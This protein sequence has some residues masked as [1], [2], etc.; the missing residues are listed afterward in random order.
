[1]AAVTI[2]TAGTY[3]LATDASFSGRLAGEQI[4]LNAAAILSITADVSIGISGGIPL[5]GA[6][7]VNR[8]KM[9]ADSRAARFLDYSTVGGTLSLYSWVKGN[10]SGAYGQVINNSA[11]TMKI[12]STSG[13]FQSGEGLTGY[14]TSAFTSTNGWTGTANSS[15][16][17]AWIEIHQQE[18]LRF[19]TWAQNANNEIYGSWY[20]LGTG[21]G[22]SAQSLT[23][24]T[25]ALTSG[26]WVQRGGV[27][28]FTNSSATLTTAQSGFSVGNCVQLFNSGGSVATNF[29]TGTKYWVVSA[30]P[31]QV[32]A[33]P[34]GS[35]IVAGSAGSGTTTIVQCGETF[36]A[37]GT[38]FTAS[39]GQRLT[40]DQEVILLSSGTL[41]TGIDEFTSY[42]I[43]N[44]NQTT[45]TFGIATSA[46]G[47]AISV[48][49]GSGTHELL[50]ISALERWVSVG[51]DAIT[52]VGSGKL[53]KYFAQSGASLTCGDGTNG[54]LFPNGAAVYV[55]N[56]TWVSATSAAPTVPSFSTSISNWCGLST[57]TST[58]IGYT[59]FQTV[60]LTGFYWIGSDSLSNNLTNVALMGM[61]DCYAQT[62]TIVG[63]NLIISA[64]GATT[65]TVNLTT[66]LLNLDNCFIH[67][68]DANALLINGAN[69]QLT[70]TNSVLSRPIRT[71]TNRT[72]ITVTASTLIVKNTA[73]FGGQLTATTSKSTFIQN[74]DFAN[75]LLSG[76]DTTQAQSIFSLGGNSVTVDGLTLAANAAGTT[77]AP[78]NSIFVLSDTYVFTVK[79]IGSAASP[80]NLGANTSSVFSISARVEVF[81]CTNVWFTNF[82][83]TGSSF[84]NSFTALLPYYD[85]RDTGVG[86]DSSIINRLKFFNVKGIQANP[87]LG[88]F[89]FLSGVAGSHFADCFTSNTQAY[90]LILLSPKVTTDST[91]N[92]AYT[93]VAG[94]PVYDGNG[95]LLMETSGDQII[96]E[97]PYYIKGATAI[98][99]MIGSSAINSTTGTTNANITADYDLDKGSGFSGTYKRCTIANLTAETGISVTTG[100]KFR[101]K[102]TATATVTI[103]GGGNSLS[104]YMGFALT[105]DRSTL[106][107]PLYPLTTSVAL[108]VS[109]C[110]A[111]ASVSIISGTT[112][113]LSGVAD[114]SGYLATTYSYDSNNPN[115][116]IKVRARKAGYQDFNITTTIPSTGII[117]PCFMPTQTNYNPSYPL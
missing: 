98:T 99:G 75:K 19:G 114:S 44:S 74:Y 112:T 57:N 64:Q 65:N 26:I 111:G 18:T 116:S 48:S 9:I 89:T 31:L 90:A 113:L 1:M 102:L 36:T 78:R 96:Y 39:G 11:A 12:R 23:H 28:T 29:A 33:S 13:R 34:G 55:P 92:A 5:L 71:N 54:N 53:G 110:V 42:Y 59:N 63:K 4:T 72:L 94:T 10:T 3:D 100:F 56:I 24:Y 38:T 80:I 95:A 79:N 76:V 14:T 101:L 85:I 107:P 70:V 8:G 17:L 21:T 6:V 83:S 105:T 60:I 61:L 108:G 86:Y 45:G 66:S 109:G 7:R 52:T 20:K 41:P 87:T 32:A 47:T 97:S 84:M 30:S 68:R 25:T 50:P 49:G 117:V 91:S 51:T 43:V 27:V 67:T 62:Q 58:T 69:S 16:R 22:T 40:N 81:T 15:Q 104:N 37:S 106:T 46:G 103:G 82:Q 2:S 88:N 115:P 93:V 73:G 35:A 77:S